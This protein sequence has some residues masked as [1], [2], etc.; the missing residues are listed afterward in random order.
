MKRTDKPRVIQN[1]EK[2]S[3]EIREQIKLVYPE[4]YIDNLIEFTNHKGELVSALPFETDD[5]IYMVRMSVRKAQQLLEI[6]SD[7]DDQGNLLDSRKEKF[8]NKYSDLGY[9]FDDDE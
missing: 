8:S 3:V 6:D 1:Y 5:K 7:F 4:G 2:L 9:L